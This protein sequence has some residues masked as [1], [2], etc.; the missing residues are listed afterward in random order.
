MSVGF[1]PTNAKSRPDVSTVQAHT[2]ASA[3]QDTCT[4]LRIMSV[5]VRDQFLTLSLSITH[6][7]A[8]LKRTV[9]RSNFSRVL[10][11][12]FFADF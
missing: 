4:T 12:C 6:M 8:L 1:T 11:I 9:W 3:L 5:R 7:H 2:C 10:L